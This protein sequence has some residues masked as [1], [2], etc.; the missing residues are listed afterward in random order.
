MQGCFIGRA[1]Q[2]S[3]GSQLAFYFVRAMIAA[4]AF[5]VAM[6]KYD[7]SIL[8]TALTFPL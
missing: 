8:S 4:L 6:F 1:R 7:Y 5:E 3:N 2:E